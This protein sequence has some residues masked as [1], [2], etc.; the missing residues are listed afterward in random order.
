MSFLSWYA[1]RYPKTRVSRWWTRKD[2]LRNSVCPSVGDI[3]LK[4]VQIQNLPSWPPVPQMFPVSTVREIFSINA[5]MI[6]RLCMTST[7]TDHELSAYL[8]PALT[9]LV[10]TVHLLPASEYEHH[11]GVGG[12]IRHSLEVAFYAANRI[13]QM[14]I[15]YVMSP[16]QMEANSKRW[17]LAAIISGLLHD[18][19]KAYTDMRVTLSDGSQ[20]QGN[21]LLFDWLVEKEAEGYFVSFV[22]GRVHKSHCEASLQLINTIVPQSTQDF[23]AAGG[24]GNEL[25]A[26]IRDAVLHGASGG[27]LGKVLTEADALSVQTDVKRQREIAPAYKNVSHP[28]ADTMLRVI[29]SLINS[30]KWTVNTPESRVF[31]TDAGV[32]IEWTKG[33]MDIREAAVGSGIQSLP[34]DPL[35]LANIMVKSTAAV[36]RQT[37]EV[38]TPLW[39]IVPFCLKDVSIAA[40]KIA[41]AQI[42]F[43]RV[44]IEQIPCIVKGEAIETSVKQLWLKTYGL[45]PVETVDPV[46]LG[47]TPELLE[48]FTSGEILV[49]ETP[50]GEL[51][52]L[53]PVVESVPGTLPENQD[54][55]A[56]GVK[57]VV[58]S[59][60]SDL[61]SP[62]IEQPIA[63]S[64]SSAKTVDLTP[65]AYLDLQEQGTSAT[66]LADYMGIRM[67]SA[68]Q[69]DA[70][71]SEAFDMSRLMPGADSAPQAQQP[72]Q[73]AKTIVRPVLASAAKRWEKSEA[74]EQA[75]EAATA[76]E[77][78]PRV[79]SV[80]EP[81]APDSGSIRMQDLMPS[82]QWTGSDKNKSDKSDKTYKSGSAGS[83]RRTD[84][85]NSNNANKKRGP[86]RKDAVSVFGAA[87]MP[88]A[89]HHSARRI[90]DEAPHAVQP[91]H[92]TE[93]EPER[94]EDFPE[95]DPGL[96]AIAEG[97]VFDDPISDDTEGADDEGDE[98]EDD[99]AQEPRDDPGVCQ[100]CGA[101]GDAAGAGS[102]DAHVCSGE[103]PAQPDAGLQSVCDGAVKS[104]PAIADE[105]ALGNIQPAEENEE[106]PGA[107]AYEG[108]DGE[109]DD[110]TTMPTWDDIPDPDVGLD[111]V[112]EEEYPQ[113][114]PVPDAPMASD[115][116]H[117]IESD[118]PQEGVPDKPE[119]PQIVSRIEKGAGVGLAAKKMTPIRT[120]AAKAKEKKK[121]GE[122]AED[123]AED[124]T[125]T[126]GKIA[127]EPAQQKA[128]KPAAAKTKRKTLSA[129]AGIRIARVQVAD[130]VAQMRAGEGK[131]I[132]SKPVL[133]NAGE[134]S[135]SSAAFVEAMDELGLKAETVATV[136][137]LVTDA[138]GYRIQLNQEQGLVV[139][140]MPTLL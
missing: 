58:V 60:K 26:S 128:P 82:S 121:A 110:V 31:V 114:T 137:S 113:A 28:Q 66:S 15:P 52:S 32:F 122:K 19:G 54:A 10:K 41:S 18:P 108:A 131:W 135:T 129:A 91:M 136:C 35:M 130:M 47:Y 77:P 83:A 133:T 134:V 8:M 107:R 125:R 90:D 75:M 30:E 92:F 93:P 38:A 23:L 29:R 13:K 89:E 39:T 21:W 127:I 139:L 53:S 98:L 6:H 94:M 88:T 11:Q 95:P 5:E 78:K 59:G 117:E 57:A 101:G 115:A 132:L 44:P 55:A 9:A 20:W 138:D 34:A 3:P 63:V 42:I 7:L 86:G 69:Q 48:E 14:S 96:D 68:L 126:K 97:V 61:K 24:F 36:P 103:L 84:A 119:S 27:I 124:K 51:V 17:V 109:K 72:Q 80:P 105:D 111:S 33:A 65:P 46:Q 64:E 50:E 118:E 45:V 99:G 112:L 81:Q 56:D 74:R 67:P 37:E 49:E 71:A 16:S 87:I 120:A 79:F 102:H 40:L 123:K 116:A 104:A 22:E 12:L 43:D 140:K 76:V 106:T 62:F 25:I 100:A 70:D 4:N 2:R 85:N 73:P 1:K